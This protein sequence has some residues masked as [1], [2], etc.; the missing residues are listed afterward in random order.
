MRIEMERC[1]GGAAEP[2]LD[3]IRESRIPHGRHGS[4]ADR[5]RQR[6]FECR[7]PAPLPAGNTTS[8][9]YSSG[10]R[11]QTVNLLTYVYG[12]S[13]PSPPIV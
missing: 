1:E 6:G 3:W 5:L 8:G 4:C 10:Q 12:G 13:N 7:I 11:G 9:G 2:L